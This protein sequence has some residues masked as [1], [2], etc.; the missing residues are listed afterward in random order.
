MGTLSSSS[1]SSWSR[2]IWSNSYWS[3]RAHCNISQMRRAKTHVTTQK[4]MA[5]PM[6][7]QCLWIVGWGKR[8][9][10][11]CSLSNGCKIR[12]LTWIT[13]WANRR[14]AQWCLTRLA[15][16]RVCRWLRG[17][18]APCTVMWSW[19]HQSR[20]ANSRVFKMITELRWARTTWIHLKRGNSGLPFKPSTTA[21]YHQDYLALTRP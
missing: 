6:S 21:S 4:A 17:C 19:S 18:E 10:R 3:R 15:K 9:R 7:Y 1:W 8:K 14:E 2:Q 13:A 12:T 20:R 5:L 16:D 11:R